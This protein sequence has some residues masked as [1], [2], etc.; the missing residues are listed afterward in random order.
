MTVGPRPSRAELRQRE[1]EVF[2]ES[3]RLVAGTLDLNEV[4]ERLA[5]IA[6]MRLEV[7]LVRIWL[8]DDRSDDVVLRARTGATRGAIESG[9]RIPVGRGLA[10]WVVAEAEP[11]ALVDVL[12]DERVRERPWFESEGIQSFLGVPIML[13]MSPIGVVACMSRSRR[14]F[15]AGDIALASS[16]A[17]PAATAVRNAGLYEEAL[18]RLEEIQAFQRV[19][20]DTLS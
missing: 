10:G 15:T 18:G 6:L 4:L 1:L 11:L 5:G 12:S 19:T 3:S 14:E 16:V 2:A 7:D 13:D 20:S 9:D 8:L 17:A